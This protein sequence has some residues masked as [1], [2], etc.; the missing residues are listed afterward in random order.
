MTAFVSRCVSCRQRGCICAQ[1]A[2]VV[3]RTR[4]VIVRHFAERWRASNTA[5]FARLAT[6]CELYDYGGPERFDE[7]RL[8]GGAGTW[9][10]Y[11]DGEPQLPSTP[12]EQVI[13]LDGS[14]SQARRMRQRLVGLRNL[15]T[16]SLPLPDPTRPR[17][18]RPTH[19]YG[20]STLEAIAR[21]VALLEGPE[22]A[23]ALERLHDLIVRAA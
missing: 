7:S 20:M 13:V 8:P 6:G 3:L 4:F 17:L 1:V 10:L 14:W 15:R 2:P 21:A 11:P 12:P 23:A 9:L 22:P 16:W 5:H 18:R 19:A